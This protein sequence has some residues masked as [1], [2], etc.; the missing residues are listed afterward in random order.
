MGF[1]QRLRDRRFE[2]QFKR[3]GKGCRFEAD[4]LEIK[5]H[6]ELGDGCVLQNNVLMRTHGAGRIVLDD[7]VTLG[8]HVLIAGNAELHI[9]ANTCIEAYCV[10]RDINHTFHGTDVHW[11][12]TPLQI[13]PITVGKDCHIG[14]HSYIM[15]GVT[16]GD[17]AVILPRS[18]VKDDVGPN[19]IWVGAPRAQC[20]GHRTDAA[21]R[22]ALKRHAD[23]LALYGFALPEEN[24]ESEAAEAP[25]QEERQ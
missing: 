10:L 23:L 2:R 20:I 4:Y 7:G 21:R 9:G 1:L 6:V 13:A 14:A 17:G 18:M 5:G 25:R 11:R 22:S 15:P 19:E 12:L 3:V 24:N 16:I 8:T